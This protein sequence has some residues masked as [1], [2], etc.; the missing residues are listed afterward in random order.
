M[1]KFNNYQSH[2]YL[3]FLWLKSVPNILKKTLGN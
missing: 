2:P 1:V 3:T